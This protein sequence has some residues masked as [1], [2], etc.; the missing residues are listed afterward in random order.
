MP[1]DERE[2]GTLEESPISFRLAGPLDEEPA[3][4]GDSVMQSPC[5]KL[6]KWFTRKE[7]GKMKAGDY[8]TET[9]TSDQ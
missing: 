4:S 7:K 9:E 3:S 8:S 1:H 6:R 5:R 2:I